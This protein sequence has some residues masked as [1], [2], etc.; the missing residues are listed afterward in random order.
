M[1]TRTSELLVL[2]R[3]ALTAVL[4]F[5]V[6]GARVVAQTRCP[7]SEL[8][9]ARAVQYCVES[10]KLTPQQQD[11]LTSASK[12]VWIR[13]QVDNIG[14]LDWIILRGDER[15]FV[16]SRRVFSMEGG[17]VLGF[18]RPICQ[19]HVPLKEIVAPASQPIAKD[20]NMPPD[21]VVPRGSC[22]CS[23]PKFRCVAEIPIVNGSTFGQV[24]THFIFAGAKA[25]IPVNR[26]RAVEKD[27][28]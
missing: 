4:F 11:L 10:L 6:V 7:P 2:I 26:K 28:T 22:L 13:F 21:P 9:A 19:S 14:P 15:V 3:S 18:S 23:N 24:R 20:G 12:E 8:T 1:D 16:V 17:V 5:S 25:I 27:P